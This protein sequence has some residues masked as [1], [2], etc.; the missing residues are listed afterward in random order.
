[1]K[2]VFGVLCFLSFLLALG[3]VGAIEQDLIDLVP[4]AI[5]AFAFI[6]LFALFGKLAGAFDYTDEGGEWE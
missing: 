2:K 1:M 5:R 3:A 4:G 6:G